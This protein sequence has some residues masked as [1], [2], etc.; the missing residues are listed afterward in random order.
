MKIIL[1]NPSLLLH[2]KPSFILYMFDSKTIELNE[3][4]TELLMVIA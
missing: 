4:E 3:L 2:D 1:D